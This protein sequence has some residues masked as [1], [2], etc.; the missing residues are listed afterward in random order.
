MTD[1][2]ELRRELPE[3]SEIADELAA[4]Q[5]RARPPMTPDE[6]AAWVAESCAVQGLPVRVTDPTTVRQVAALLGASVRGAESPTTHD[7]P[8]ARVASDGR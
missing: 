3:L 6:L 1:P 4:R 2:D 7:A 5:R 8:A